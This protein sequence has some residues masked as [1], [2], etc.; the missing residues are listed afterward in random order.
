MAAW[1][2]VLAMAVVAGTADAQ[3]STATVQGKVSDQTGVLP[4]VTVTARD[5]GS[6]FTRDATTDGEG[7]YSLAGLVPGTYEIRVT[8]DQYKP[9]ART[10]QVLVGRTITVDFSVSPDL[11]YTET[12]QVVSER[13][14]DI[15][16]ME[17]A[18]NVTQEQLQHLPQNTRNFLNFAA[19]APGVRVADNEFRKESPRARCRRRTP[20]CS[21]TASATRTT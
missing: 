2:I 9:Q 6:G 10:V 14:R 5:T 20:M 18:T 15:R 7:L 1:G 17:V 12:V 11:V 21:S 3:I 8:L 19:L 4:G 13:L 16:T